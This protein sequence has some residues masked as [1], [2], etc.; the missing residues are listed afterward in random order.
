MLLNGQ[1]VKTLEI[2]YMRC[3]LHHD[4]HLFIGTEEEM[5]FMISLPDFTILDRFITQS[6]VFSI[7]ALDKTR[8]V[9]GQYQG[10]IDIL[11]ISSEEGKLS[12]LQQVRPFTAN[13]YKIV[14]LGDGNLV[15]GCGNGLFFGKVI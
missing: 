11:Q 12:K 6:Y 10:F 5:I 3:S 7:E 15:F 9:V 13:V 8:L 14:S 1:K 4:N 2:E